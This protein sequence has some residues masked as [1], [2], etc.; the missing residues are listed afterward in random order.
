MLTFD[1]FDPSLA[2]VCSPPSQYSSRLKFQ[3]PEDIQLS[4]KYNVEHTIDTYTLSGSC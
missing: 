1:L 4:S 2:G 3:L